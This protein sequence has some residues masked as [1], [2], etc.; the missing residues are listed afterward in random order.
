MRGYE[1]GRGNLLIN[2]ESGVREYEYERENLQ[3]LMHVRRERGRCGE[4]ATRERPL[5]DYNYEGRKAALQ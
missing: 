5:R 2:K 4:K 1:Y 3:G